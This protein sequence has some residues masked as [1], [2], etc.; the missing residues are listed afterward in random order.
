MKD[1]I[2]FGI[3]GCGDVTEKK[4][5]PAFQ[6]V[7]GSNLYA[8]MRRDREKLES[9]SQ[10]HGVEKYSTDYRELLEDPELNAIYVATPP[11]KHCFYTI[12]AA[13]HGKAVYVEKPMAVSVAECREMIQACKE[14]D[15]PL[16]AAYYRR[17]QEKFR[18]VKELIENG[19]IGTVRSF[20]YQYTSKV[21]AGDPNR[22]WLLDKKAAGGGLLYDIGSH[23]IDTILY[24]FGDVRSA[25]G[26]S[27][28]QSQ[29]HDVHDNTTGFIQF[30]N[31]VQ[32]SLQLTFNG[33]QHRDELTVV[34]SE[35]TIVFSIMSNDPVEL[36]EE[37][38]KQTFRFEALEHVQEP[39]IRRVVNTLRGNDDYPADGIAGLRTQEILEA[40][41]NSESVTYS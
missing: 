21:P 23:M 29:V 15:V 27:A 10:R 16:F 11:D 3:I 17:E 6:K 8:V 1:K 37:D 12:E 25:S 41:E 14:H 33:L 18:K 31:G 20:S 28:N 26:V 19:S 34:G 2:N 13:K 22:D 36:F 7:E 30:E 35:G 5:G 39:L 9:Y 4:S 40:F 38:N 32:G 24:L